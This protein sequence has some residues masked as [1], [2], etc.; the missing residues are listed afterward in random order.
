MIMY[1][2]IFIFYNKKAK[3]LRRN[4]LNCEKEKYSRIM[5]NNMSCNLDKDARHAI[6]TSKRVINYE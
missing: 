2:I 5:R 6:I 4:S 3:L 1:L